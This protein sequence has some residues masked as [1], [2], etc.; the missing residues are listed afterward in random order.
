M[1]MPAPAAGQGYDY[2]RV[3]T[4][5]IRQTVLGVEGVWRPVC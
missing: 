2:P 4:I 3:F 5:V 1:S